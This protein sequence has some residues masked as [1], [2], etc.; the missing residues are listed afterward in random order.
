MQPIE[1]IR[2]VSSRDVSSRQK[3]GQVMVLMLSYIDGPLT[4]LLKV[5]S[6]LGY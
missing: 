5:Q 6:L 3:W 4:I 2:V 1:L